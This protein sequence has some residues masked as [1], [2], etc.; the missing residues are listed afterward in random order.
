MWPVCPLRP[1]ADVD[2]DG[3]SSR[4]QLRSACGVDLRRAREQT[5]RS[6]PRRALDD[7][8]EPSPHLGGDGGELVV[9]HDRE[10]ALGVDRGDVR[11]CRRAR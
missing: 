11:G 7:R 1:A 3:V 4:D 8:C 10:H 9:A 2:D 5:A 6:D